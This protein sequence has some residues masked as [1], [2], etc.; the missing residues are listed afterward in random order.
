MLI[1]PVESIRRCY[2]I[3]NIDM[4]DIDVCDVDFW[5]GGKNYMDFIFI[6][7]ETVA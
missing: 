1:K 3:G 4:L 5:I 7:K 2:G 6:L